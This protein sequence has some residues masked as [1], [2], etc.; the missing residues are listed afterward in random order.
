MPTRPEFFSQISEKSSIIMKVFLYIWKN[1][2]Y[3]KQ[4][5]YDQTLTVPAA[6]LEEKPVGASTDLLLGCW[7]I[8]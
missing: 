7:V 5:G 3:D 8:F 2:W 6:Q 1:L 4:A